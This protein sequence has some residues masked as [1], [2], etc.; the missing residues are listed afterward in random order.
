MFPYPRPHADE[1]DTI[2]SL[3]DPVAKFFESEV[4]SK[5]MDESKKIPQVQCTETAD[6]LPPTK[7]APNLTNNSIPTGDARRAEGDGTVRPPDRRK[8]QRPERIFFQSMNAA[9]VD[10]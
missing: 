1:R 3:V 2:M 5:A 7:T 4:D 6:Q 10:V 9:D 8:P